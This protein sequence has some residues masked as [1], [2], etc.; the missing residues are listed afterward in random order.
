MW[1]PFCLWN[2]DDYVRHVIMSALLLFKVGEIWSQWM[3]AKTHQATPQGLQ[4]FQIKPL[5]GGTQARLSWD[6]PS[7]VRGQIPLQI[8]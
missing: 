4:L 6:P 7:N 8:G 3:D 1:I 5:E 2:V